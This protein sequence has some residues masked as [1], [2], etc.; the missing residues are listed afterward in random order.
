VVKSLHHEVRFEGTA[1][2]MNTS[3]TPIPGGVAVSLSATGR[4]THFGRFTLEA[5]DLVLFTSPTTVVIE[6]GV[7]TLT[8]PDGDQV[9]F[10]YHGT[11][12]V[13]GDLLVSD[14]DVTIT[15]GTGKFAGATGSLVS[16]N[17]M[18]NLTTEAVTIPLAGVIRRHG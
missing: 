4:A 1:T 15:G 5:T 3:V 7:G 13:N 18:T 10:T 16:R 12:T 6:N 2:G 17:G 11:G 14:L 8:R 9:T